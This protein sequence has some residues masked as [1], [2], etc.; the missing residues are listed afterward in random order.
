MKS[1]ILFLFGILCLQAQEFNHNPYFKKLLQSEDYGLFKKKLIPEKAIV[2]TKKEKFNNK[3]APTSNW[4][5]I[6]PSDFEV[7]SGWNPGVGRI[8]ALAIDPN[9]PKIIYAG[10]PLGGLWK[11]EDG[12]NNWS[13]LIDRYNFDSDNQFITE[14]DVLG[15]SCIAIDPKN[16]NIIY[17]GSGDVIGE[18]K[19]S[20]GI[21]RST[22]GGKTWMQRG[23][24]DG[25][26]FFFM[27][28]IVINPVDSN[29]ILC[30]DDRE[31][32]ISKNAG[33]TWNTANNVAFDFGNSSLVYKPGSLT[34]VY[35]ASTFSNSFFT[36]E[37]RYAEYVISTDSGSNY[38]NIDSPILPKNAKIVKLAVTKANPNYLYLGATDAENKFL[39]IFRSI[40]S[41]VNWEKMTTDTSDVTEGFFNFTITV[42]DT[43]PLE[44]YLG[45]F[46]AWK[47]IDGGK[48]FAKLTEWNAPKTGKYV[49]PYINNMYFNN[50]QLYTVSSVGVYQSFDNGNSF[51][52]KNKGLQVSLGIS[53]DVSK[54]SSKKILAG[55]EGI[56]GM[57]LSNGSWK[58]YH[59]A[60]G[61]NCA[62]DP[63]NENNLYGVSQFGYAMY[64]SKD[65]GVTIDTISL[66]KEESS[67]VYR[68]PMAINSKG[69]V[70]AS[71]SNLYKLENNEWKKQNLTPLLP[72]RNGR[73]DD[74][75]D[76]ITIAP[77]VDN[78]IYILTGQ[79]LY[80]SIDKGINFELMNAPNKYYDFLNMIVQDDNPNIIYATDITYVFKSIDG[81]KTFSIIKDNDS[82]PNR[83]Y[84]I[85]H[86]PRSALNALYVSST[87]GDIYYTDD[88]LTDWVP[89][90]D[91][92]LPKNL[93][94]DLAINTIDN[95]IIAT[96]Y[97]RGLWESPLPA[98]TLNQE[99]FSNNS[100]E[101]IV[102]FPNPVKNNVS[103]LSKNNFEIGSVEIYDFLGNFISKIDNSNLETEKNIDLNYLSSGIYLFKIEI[104]NEIVYKRIIK[105]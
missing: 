92:E 73:Y 45:A 83:P 55:M 100:L 13:L 69:E 65:A 22:D 36:G 85:V 57:Y 39:G 32:Y 97:G 77:S 5:P 17:I 53:L 87:F 30:S 31:I 80:K 44:V 72:S 105:E 78:V 88:S 51:T 104:N 27:S 101:D 18:K 2:N 56:G 28:N 12:G 38:K 48:T 7:T 74:I 75:I 50:N 8:N 86:H 34:T 99:E 49:G 76:L 68:G 43:N 102:V 79:Y 41:G 94:S 89:F 14:P 29:I 15:V 52:S 54:N 6:G 98:T 33:Q 37:P 84:A 67:S 23:L 21:L 71:F 26:P 66:P 64:R 10:A 58:S 11:S 25:R 82:K 81:G 40:D 20:R 42:S 60:T 16:S 63:S 4:S 47:S 62:I 90:Y 95:K 70:Y 3:M 96:T 1:V 91:N 19:E 103:I 93:I 59:G 35:S 46:N 24:N 9:N 61:G